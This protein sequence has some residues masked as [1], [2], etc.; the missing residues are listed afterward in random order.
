MGEWQELVVD[1][2]A[3][4]TPVQFGDTIYLRAWASAVDAGVGAR[5]DGR[6]PAVTKGGPA[7]TNGGGPPLAVTKGG[8]SGPHLMAD[9]NVAD[10]ERIVVARWHDMGT[11]QAIEVLRASP[12]TSTQQEV[13]AE[14]VADEEAEEEVQMV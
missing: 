9:P 7:V 6:L 1:G 2:R 10:A 4:G 5:R 3:V 13:A 11:W 8:G 14:V 12:Y